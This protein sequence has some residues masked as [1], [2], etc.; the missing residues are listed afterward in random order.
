[1]NQNKFVQSK[2]VYFRKWTRKSFGAFCSLGKLVKIC[3]LSLSYTLLV[4]PAKAKNT[5]QDTVVVK[6]PQEV[7]LEEVEITGQRTPAVFSEIGRA[8]TVITKKE[9]ESSPAQSLED[10]LEY[11]QSVDIRQRNTN[12]VQADVQMRGGSFDQVLILLNGINITDPQTGH[13][14]LNLPVNIDQIERIEILHGSASRVYGTNAY[15]G[16]INFITSN[17]RNNVSANLAYG[18]HSFLQAGVSGSISN[19]NFSNQVSFNHKSSDG[20]AQSTDFE[21]NNLYYQARLAHENLS[22]TLAIGL[23]KKAYGANTFY[24][25]RFPDQYEETNSQFVTLRS[26]YSKI[27]DV[28]IDG[29]WRRH[30]DHFILIRSNPPA[31]ENFHR[32]DIAGANADTYFESKLGKTSI[33]LNYR[34]ET[35]LSN[36][37]GEDI[38]DPIE[39]KSADS[40]F[41]YKSY[42][43][44]YING[45][46]EQ[47]TSLGKLNIVAGSL[48]EV[49]SESNK[50]QFYPGVDLSYP[51]LDQ[52]KIYSSLNRSMRLPTFTDMFYVDPANEGTPHLKPEKIISYEGGISYSTPALF[53]N[54]TYFRDYA[55]DV[56][57]WLWL[58]DR[59]L[60]KAT[61]FSE[62]TTQG[63]EAKIDYV[64]AGVP[65]FE[66]LSVSWAINNVSK[67]EQEYES[68][69]VLDHLKNKIGIKSHFTFFEDFNFT[70]Y[71]TYQERNGTYLFYNSETSTTDTKKFRPYWL[72][73]AKLSWNKNILTIFIEASNIFDV[74][75]IDVGSLIQPGRWVKSGFV[76]NFDYGKF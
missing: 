29:Y 49:N 18:E 16:V 21:V 13:F 54:V 22:N 30:Y 14:N 7:D 31:Y 9:I 35:I 20:Y 43:R 45:F 65:I 33:G 34:Y 28:K 17:Q 32:T 74:D 38:S 44:N 46:I 19:S 15:K 51:I 72:S 61:N 69:Y 1:M 5:D 57:D 8:I 25:P 40:A 50:L 26:R 11:A 67:Q 10:L 56:I 24:S 59:E 76:V 70:F 41:Y 36:V 2:T 73:D 60:Y 55:T 39:V 37:L 53:A 58:I 47:S 63:I 3:S 6:M 52:V 64:F 23:T 27:L 66:K 42:S 12:G 48:L 4:L 62:I 75:Y 71:S 68:K